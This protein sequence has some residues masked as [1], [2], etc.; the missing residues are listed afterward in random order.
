[1][2]DK[3]YWAAFHGD[4]KK[5]KDYI[6]TGKYNIKK[7]INGAIESNNINTLS[8]L[9]NCNIEFTRDETYKLFSLCGR[10]CDINILNKIINDFRN[11][12]NFYNFI[13]MAFDSACKTGRIKMMD[14]IFKEYKSIHLNLNDA[15][16]NVV[17]FSMQNSIRWLVKNGATNL[18]DALLKAAKEADA[19]SIQKLISEGA[20]NLKGALLIFITIG[21]KK[22]KG[23]LFLSEE[24]EY[25]AT[26]KMFV[27]KKVYTKNEILTL[28][29]DN[30]VEKRYVNLFEIT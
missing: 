5:T 10:Y 20:T 4:V 6:N 2:T 21:Y 22:I 1:M 11:N 27:K 14:Y 24:Q 28:L 17:G 12:N 18:N 3:L 19:V 23:S 8:E 9:L 16:L 15:L 29:K 26:I 25:V 7:A 30:K 13:K